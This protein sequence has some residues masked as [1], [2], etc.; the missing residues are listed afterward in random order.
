MCRGARRSTRYTCREPTR[1]SIALH[2]RGCLATL[3]VSS[4]ATTN[5]QLDSV[6][7][8]MLCDAQ[9]GVTHAVAQACCWN[10]FALCVRGHDRGA[11][12]G[13]QVHCW[14][15]TVPQTPR[16]QQRRSLCCCRVS[17]S[18]AAGRRRTCG[19]PRRSWR[20]STRSSWAS[21]S[22]SGGRAVAAPSRQAPFPAHRREPG[23]T[24]P[25]GRRPAAC[26][27]GA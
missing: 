23:A 1:I 13:R 7:C 17:C 24:L 10:W 18:S 2:K 26:P 22:S 5:C 16:R 8:C 19:A 9:R 14:G 6:R 15:R 4:Q 12:Q 3:P 20:S 27:L 25:R 11:V 21:P